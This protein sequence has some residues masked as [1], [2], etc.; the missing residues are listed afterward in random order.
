MRFPIRV[1]HGNNL[2]KQ[3]LAALD[4]VTEFEFG[5][6]NVANGGVATSWDIQLE[7]T[8]QGSDLNL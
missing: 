5:T 7:Y 4:V 2:G 8:R 1:L 6:T 3:K